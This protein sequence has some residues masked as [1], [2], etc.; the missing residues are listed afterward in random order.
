MSLIYI[1]GTPGTG[2]STLRKELEAAGFEAHD[3]DDKDMGGPFNLATRKRVVYPESPSAEWFSRHQYWIIPEA[4]AGLQKKARE[5]EST[6][7]LVGTGHNEPDILGYVDHIFFLDATKAEVLKRVAERT[8]SDYGHAP[9]EQVE[10]AEKYD[11]DLAY[12]ERPGVVRINAMLPVQ[13]VLAQVI[14]ETKRIENVA[15]S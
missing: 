10:I 9:H 4:V 6:I 7:F 15:N 3:A 8:N 14:D 11:R 5:D 13:Q 1:K 12:L 2:K